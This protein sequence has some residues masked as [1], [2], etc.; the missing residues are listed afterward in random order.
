MYPQDMLADQMGSQARRTSEI[1]SQ[2]SA[3]A[4]KIGVLTVLTGQLEETL[5]PVLRGKFP[6][7]ATNEKAHREEVP[8]ASDIQNLSNALDG[9][10]TSQQH[11]LQRIAL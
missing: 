11:L 1:R 10:I 3:L 9:I 6:T 8:I 7:E 5:Q 4:E 2:L